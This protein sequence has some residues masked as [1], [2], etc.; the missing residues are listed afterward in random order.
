LPSYNLE[1]DSTLTSV[2]CPTT[3]KCWVTGF[4]YTSTGTAGVLLETT[5]GGSTW[6]QEPVP[7]NVG[8]LTGISCPTSSYCQAVGSKETNAGVVL[9]TSNGGVI[10]QEQALPTQLGDLAGVSCPGSGRC[11]VVG[12]TTAGGAAIAP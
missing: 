10:W 9:V 6:A 8:T 3:S 2:S 5:D 11:Q 7:A 12:Q 1:T 4:T